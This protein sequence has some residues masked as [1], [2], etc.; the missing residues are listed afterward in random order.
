MASIPAQGVRR[1]KAS[2][3]KAPVGAPLPH[4]CEGKTEGAPR[5]FQK[6]GAA[7]RWLNCSAGCLKI[8]S[9][10][11]DAGA[12]SSL[13]R[14][15]GIPAA[16]LRS[17]TQTCFAALNC[18]L[19]WDVALAARSNALISALA[20]AVR[21][22]PRLSAGLAFEFGVMVGAFIK[23]ARVRGIKGASA[24]LIEAVPLIAQAPSARRSHRKA[25]APK[26][27]TA[28]RAPRTKT[29]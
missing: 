18:G 15:G 14:G 12:P 10:L 7:E 27:K 19:I 16:V 28:R 4:V 3:A 1:G 26:R 29:A 8:E 21:L 20:S 2:I 23:S 11:F 17:G 24:K 13:P 9:V 6:T 25:A 5:A 22:N